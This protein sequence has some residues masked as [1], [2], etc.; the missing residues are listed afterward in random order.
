M[1]KKFGHTLGVCAMLTLVFIISFG[2]KASAKTTEPITLKDTPFDVP[3]KKQDVIKNCV[4]SI[5]NLDPEFI[6]LHNLCEE[7]RFSEYDKEN[8]E[9]YSFIYLERYGNVSASNDHVLQAQIDRRNDS[10]VE[11]FVRGTK[12]EMLGLAVL[13]QEKYGA[14]KVKTALVENTL[15]Q[16]FEKQIFTWSD[17][18]GTIMTIETMFKTIT[19]GALFIKSRSFLKFES[20]SKQREI[21]NFKSLKGDL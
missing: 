19:D 7:H 4:S 12:E 20:E 10:L 1:Y 2:E 13:L 18:N 8:Y 5:A 15:G 9:K 3:N 11:V 21:E 16:N 14:P 17:K 6:R